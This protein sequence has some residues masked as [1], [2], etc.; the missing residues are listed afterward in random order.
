MMVALGVDGIREGHVGVV[1]HSIDRIGRVGHLAGGGEELFFCGREHVR[2]A[3]SNVV[4]IAAVALQ[5]RQFCIEFLHRFIGDRHDLR[6][7]EAGGRLER[8]VGAHQAAHHGLIFGNSCILIGAA[9]GVV[10]QRI[11]KHGDFFRQF[12]IVK[13]I[14]RRPAQLARKCGNRWDQVLRLL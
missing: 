12:H 5:F 6:G 8:H 9:H 2:A 14:L 11:G 10:A 13:Q 1:E 7:G 4:Q 3:A